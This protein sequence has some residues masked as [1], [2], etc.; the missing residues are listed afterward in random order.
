MGLLARLIDEIDA[1]FVVIATLYALAQKG[2]LRR[3]TV[4]K[5][6]EDL[7]VDPEKAYPFH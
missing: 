3:E 4:T 1:E 6:I 5:A 2:S 7:K